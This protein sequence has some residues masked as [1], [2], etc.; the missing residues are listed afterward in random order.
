MSFSQCISLVEITA[1]S[2]TTMQMNSGTNHLPTTPLKSVQLYKTPTLKDQFLVN[3]C[4]EQLH[5]CCFFL[6]SITSSQKGISLPC[7]LVVSY[8]MTAVSR[9]SRLAAAAAVS[10]WLH[11]SETCATPINKTVCT[12]GTMPNCSHLC[13]S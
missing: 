5:D 6:S 10:G 13:V 9:Q 11:G 4:S 2:T 12:G 8:C 7:G 1:D 3:S